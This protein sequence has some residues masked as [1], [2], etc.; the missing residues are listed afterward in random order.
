MATCKL[1]VEIKI[2][3]WV[4]VYLRMLTLFCVMKRCEPDYRKVGEIIAK[5]GLRRTFSVDE[6]G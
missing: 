6:L 4:R 1:S 5:Y 3:W 2:R